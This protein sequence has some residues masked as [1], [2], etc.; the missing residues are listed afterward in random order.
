MPS[1]FQYWRSCPE[2]TM[3]VVQYITDD[4]RTKKITYKTFA[5]HADLSRLRAQDHPAM[6]R[7]SAPDNWAI[8]FWKSQLP[9]GRPIYYFDWSRI[10]H[11]FID[12][13][14][15]P[16]LEE[17]HRLAQRSTVAEAPRHRYSLEELLDETPS[18]WT[19]LLE[20]YTR[21][22]ATISLSHQ[23]GALT[24]SSNTYMDEFPEFLKRNEPWPTAHS[25][26]GAIDGWIQASDWADPT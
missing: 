5:K 17:E 1:R 6:W 11:V 13:N 21:E 26:M 14:N 4:D 7:I 9:S 10:E 24:V 3:E 22:N 20:A 25:A 8:S 15:P 23:T 2:L 19:R 16:T 18:G 12:P